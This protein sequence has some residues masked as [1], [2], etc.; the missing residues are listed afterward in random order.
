MPIV[1]SIALFQT[2]SSH[3]MSS[4][5]LRTR[6][7]EL[8]YCFP[9][10]SA[11]SWFSHLLNDNGRTN[12]LNSFSFILHRTLLLFIL[13]GTLLHL[14]YQETG[15]RE[16]LRSWRRLKNFFLSMLWVILNLKW[17]HCMTNE[18]LYRNLLKVGQ[19]DR[20]KTAA[21]LGSLCL[22]LL[23]PGIFQISLLGS[24][25]WWEENAVTLTSNNLIADP[26]P[27]CIQDVKGVMLSRE[28]L[29]LGF[30]AVVCVRAQPLWRQW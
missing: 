30:V 29:Q 12:I 4:V 20:A 23:Q 10:L 17:Q 28:V 15:I 8:V 18:R 5:L 16:I 19:E 25:S 9:F 24:I 3:L 22:P 21:S 11:A 2:L 1:V 6:E 14:F 7:F 26:G 27:K 13:L